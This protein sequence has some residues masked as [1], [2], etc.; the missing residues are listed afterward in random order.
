MYL[1]IASGF[2]STTL[3]CIPGAFLAQLPFSGL[4]FRELQSDCIC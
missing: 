4:E 2:L 3:E 1:R